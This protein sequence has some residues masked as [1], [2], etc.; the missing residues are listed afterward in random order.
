MEFPSISISDVP[1]VTTQQMIEV[2]RLMIETY[3]IQLI[4]M[5]TD[6]APYT[7]PGND[8]YYNCLDVSLVAAVPEP[9]GWMLLALGTMMV[10]PSRRRTF[11]PMFSNN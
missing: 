3:R 1:T 8:I 11:G 4:Q 5:M 6:K 2:D 7:S 10:R 9:S